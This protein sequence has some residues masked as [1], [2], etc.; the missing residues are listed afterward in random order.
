MLRIAKLL[1][2][3]VWNRVANQVN[4]SAILSPTAARTFAAS[5]SGR[6]DRSNS[7]RFPNVLGGADETGKACEKAHDLALHERGEQNQDE[8]DAEKEAEED[9]QARETTAN[10]PGFDSIHQ[11]IEDIGDHKRCCKKQHNALQQHEREE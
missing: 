2:I 9:N 4:A 11:G 10:S 1:V 8:N 3:I 6:C 5:S 7:I